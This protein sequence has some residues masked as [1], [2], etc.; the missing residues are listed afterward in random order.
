VSD[1]GLLLGLRTAYLSDIST[2]LTASI[3]IV[4]ELVLMY[5]AAVR[6]KTCDGCTKRYEGNWQIAATEDGRKGQNCPQPMTVQYFQEDPS[7]F[8][9]QQWDV[10][11]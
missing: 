3:F 6:N 1:D 10:W 4:S 11:N 2:F 7:F 8:G 5:T 9:H